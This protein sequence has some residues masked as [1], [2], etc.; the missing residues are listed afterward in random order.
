M[1]LLFYSECVINPTP[2][3]CVRLFVAKRY[4]SVLGKLDKTK[5]GIEI[6]RPC[7]CD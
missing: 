1:I 3:L 5:A 6:K 4:F 7:V 2:S